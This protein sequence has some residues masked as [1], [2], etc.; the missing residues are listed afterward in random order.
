MYKYYIIYQITNILNA[1][2]YIGKHST[3][4][5]EDSY[6]GSGKLIRAAI[7]KY[8]K[9]NFVKTILFT[10]DNEHD[11]NIKEKELITEDFV[12]RDDTDNLGVGGE[13]GAHFKGRKH[14]PETI[15]KISKSNMKR[16]YS[17]KTRNKISTSLKKIGEHISESK[18]G[19]K[20]HNFGLKWI[21]NID[22]NI[23][24]MIPCEQDIPDG[25]VK[26]RKMV[27]N[28]EKWSAAHK[29]KKRTNETKKKISDA[30]KRYEKEKN[31]CL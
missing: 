15:E 1:K 10:F 13:G 21:T 20:N 14:S 30:R 24:K 31:K 16:F 6:L 11:M 17:E 3:N 25:Y 23:S 18:R 19:E 26:G 4:N 22:T 7:L 8:G 5:I 27:Y 29:G 12:R 9:P 28:I 2:I